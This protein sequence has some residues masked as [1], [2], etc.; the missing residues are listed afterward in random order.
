MISLV[1]DHTHRYSLSPSLSLW[2]PHSL[3]ILFIHLCSMRFSSI[4][5]WVFFCLF[6]FVLV[7]FKYFSMESLM[8]LPSGKK[9]HLLNQHVHVGEQIEFFTEHWLQLVV[10]CGNSFNSKVEIQFSA[11][12]TEKKYKL[13]DGLCYHQQFADTHLKS[14]WL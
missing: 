2:L 7:H 10:F 8:W 4:Y 11:R 12:A 13:F 5:N 1:S 14:K 9:L 3:F 6:F